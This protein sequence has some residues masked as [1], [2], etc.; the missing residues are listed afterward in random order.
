[1]NNLFRVAQ[2]AG[3]GLDAA[4]TY[5]SAL[6]LVECLKTHIPHGRLAHFWIIAYIW[7][8]RPLLRMSVINAEMPVGVDDGEP[9]STAQGSHNDAQFLATPPARRNGLDFRLADLQWHQSD[10]QDERKK[11]TISNRACGVWVPCS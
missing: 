3:V 10:A 4:K 2:L 8:T 6:R 5:D 7:E 11:S 1:M 9:H